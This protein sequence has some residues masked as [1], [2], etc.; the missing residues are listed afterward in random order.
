MRLEDGTSRTD[1]DLADRVLKVGNTR[2]IQE[3]S[4]INN[5]SIANCNRLVHLLKELF[6]NTLSRR[7][8]GKVTETFEYQHYNLMPGICFES[9]KLYSGSHTGVLVSFV[10]L[11]PKNCDT[12]PVF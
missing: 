12:L 9:C 7:L 3:L 6:K 10:T 4:P 1:W 2:L 5:N 11:S 8:E